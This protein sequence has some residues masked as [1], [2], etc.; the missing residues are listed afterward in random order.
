MENK[1]ELVCPECNECRGLCRRLLWLPDWR[2]NNFGLHGASFPSFFERRRLS[3]ADESIRHRFAD[4][5]RI[6]V[7]GRPL[8]TFRM[9]A[10]HHR[11]ESTGGPAA[12]G[13]R[14][15]AGNLRG[16]PGSD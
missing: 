4:L 1:I 8:F 7:Q 12:G 9:T 16:C 2:Q 11:Q 13:W 14:N 5:C 3:L 10:F 6:P 15:N